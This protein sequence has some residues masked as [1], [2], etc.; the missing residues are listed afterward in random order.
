[1]IYEEN[2]KE[3]KKIA[4]K[5]RKR[6]L[7]MI[8]NSQSGHIG[9]SLSSVEAIVSLYFNVM[10]LQGSNRDRFILSKG[11]GVPALY[12]VLVEKNWMD[13]KELL[14]LRRLGSKLQGHPDMKTNPYID[15]S[16][17]SLGQGLSVGVGMALGAKLQKSPAKVYTL[18][19][20]G[21][22][23]EGQNYEAMMFASHH[24]LNNLIA[25][26]DNN[27]LQLDG[28][29]K[30]ILALEPLEKRFEAFGWKIE[31]CDG[32]NFV[33]IINALN[34]LKNNESGPGVVILNTIKGKGISFME[35]KVKYHGA[36]PNEEEY[37]RALKELENW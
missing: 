37:L 27:G 22:L 35:N 26:V 20:D 4:A 19:G 11:H 1:M 5:T 8:F 21:E 23:E 24:K 36:P 31:V 30:E 17:G 32:H 13:E 2:L 7:E 10:N 9:G 25:L 33:E 6:I 34:R 15:M 3:L 29:T 28:P 16:S 14:T 18:V 12:A